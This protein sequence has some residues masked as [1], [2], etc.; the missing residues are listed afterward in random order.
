MGRGTRVVHAG[1]HAL[2][3]C[4]QVLRA[5]TPVAVEEGVTWCSLQLLN[6]QISGTQASRAAALPF[7]PA[8]SPSKPLI[9]SHSKFL[10]SAAT[11][12]CEA[13][14]TG[15]ATAEAQAEAFA[16]VRQL[17][18]PVCVTLHL[19]PSHKYHGPKCSLE[20]ALR[21]FLQSGGNSALRM[22]TQLR[23]TR[24]PLPPGCPLLQAY[25]DALAKAQCG[26]SIAAGAASAQAA[27]KAFA[28]AAA[29]AGRRRAG[30]GWRD[31]TRA[32]ITAGR[33]GGQLIAG[34]CSSS[35]RQLRARGGM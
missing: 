21:V 30:R 25:A 23:F 34:G 2:I 28:R 15:K 3:A 13:R 18:D 24:S 31:G 5:C 20:R 14:T 9:H 19:Q 27:S 8:G 1:L 16:T 6:F 29:L 35:L 17:R 26:K 22:L 10:V 4:M 11:E 33:P 12:G 32:R 7:V